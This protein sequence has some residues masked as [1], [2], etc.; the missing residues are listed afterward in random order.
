MIQVLRRINWGICGLM[1]VLVLAVLLRTQELARVGLHCDE[2]FAQRMVEFPWSEIFDRI[3]LDTHPPLYYV[4]YKS[5]CGL[6]GSGVAVGRM[7]SVLFGVAAVAGMY[8]FVRE[9]CRFGDQTLKRR[10]LDDQLPALLAA[11]LLALTPLQIFWSQQIRMY[12][13]GVAL[14]TWSSY[15][16]LRVCR[17]GDRAD[18]IAYTLS[19]ALLTHTHYFGLFLVA[20]Q[21]TY[22]AGWSLV[23]PQVE[24]LPRARSIL[25]AVGSLW[26]ASQPWLPYFLQQRQ[27]VAD[28][29]FLPKPSWTVLG[30]IFHEVWIDFLLPTSPMPGLV[31][32]Q[33]L[34]IVLLVL[35]ARRSPGDLLILTLTALPLAAVLVV[36][37]FSRSLL[38]GRYFLILQPVWI[39]AISIVACRLWS[40]WRYAALVLLSLVLA[41]NSY[42]HWTRRE[43]QAHL[44][45]MA[46]AIS[47]VDA[48]RGNDPLVVSNPLLYVSA[49][50]YSSN[51]PQL[52]LYRPSHGFPF[53]QGTAAIRDEQYLDQAAIQRLSTATFWTLDGDGWMGRVPAPEG[54]RLLREE[55]APDGYADLKVRLYAPP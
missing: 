49:V 1:F 42:E 43:N 6:F 46:A 20:A 48:V 53:F 51:R 11:L 39:A 31:F 50:S 23:A 30:H 26:F 14:T 9:A 17:R 10:F 33:L 22:L 28:N 27:Q 54:W 7:L 3:G 41:R 2:G 55:S 8:F 52:H 47:R 5:W 19:A 38:N 25:L 35:L 16:L 18:W 29:F 40:P 34:F 36:S 12:S 24:R 21:F 13:L 4:L 44:P 15:L 37:W 32:T 45:G